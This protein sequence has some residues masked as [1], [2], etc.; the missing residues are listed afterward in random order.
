[1]NALTTTFLGSIRAILLNFINRNQISARDL[2]CGRAR[3]PRKISKIVGKNLEDISKR[4]AKEIWDSFHLIRLIVIR[5]T[6]HITWLP[7]LKVAHIVPSVIYGN[8]PGLSRT[9]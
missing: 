4:S 1:M 8:A 3:L 5:Y 6:S 2:C 9:V 7:N